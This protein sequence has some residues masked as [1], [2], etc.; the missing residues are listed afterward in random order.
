MNPFRTYDDAF[1]PARARS[2]FIGMNPCTVISA[3]P[4]TTLI[5]TVWTELS[6]TFIVVPFR[7]RRLIALLSLITIFLL[8]FGGPYTPDFALLPPKREEKQGTEPTR[9]TDS[10]GES[11]EL[12]GPAGFGEF[13]G[14]GDLT[15]FFTAYT[16]YFR[17]FGLKI[18]RVNRRV[19]PHPG[20]V[21][22]RRNSVSKLTIA[23]PEAQPCG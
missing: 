10:L 9:R 6:V 18:Y 3:L 23:D 2:V 5:S 4:F 20:D 19:V 11:T 8:T 16:P 1:L 7:S 13:I 17:P 12:G 22:R 21:E 14:T 15:L